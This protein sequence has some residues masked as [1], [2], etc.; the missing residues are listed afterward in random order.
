MLQAVRCAELDCIRY[1]GVEADVLAR[2]A[3]LGVPELC[4]AGAR[5]DMRAVLRNQATF[6]FDRESVREPADLAEVCREH[7]L[8]LGANRYRVTPVGSGDG[9]A[10]FRCA[11]FEDQFHLITFSQGPRPAT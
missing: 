4:D 11:W 7:L 10:S 1:R 9:H 5:L 6:V 8:A 3:E 2:F